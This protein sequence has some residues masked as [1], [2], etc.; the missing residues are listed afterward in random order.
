MKLRA[1]YIVLSAAIAIG[2]IAAV[3]LSSPDRIAVT[4]KCEPDSL[5]SEIRSRVQG[6]RFWSEQ[7]ESIDAYL[8]RRA[9]AYESSK[10]MERQLS[11]MDAQTNRLMQEVYEKNPNLRPTPAQQRAERLRQ[12]ANAIEARET[13]MMIQQMESE[14]A[15]DLDRC[16]ALFRL[17]ERSG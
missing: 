14:R 13:E 16:K 15:I 8:E 11:L 2:L 6:T 12:Q 9:R 5:L 17:L 3:L 4:A 10:Q 1:R 7:I